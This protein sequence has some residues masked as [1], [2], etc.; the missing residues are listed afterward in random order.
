[1]QPGG[2]W[3]ER[4]SDKSLTTACRLKGVRAPQS[5]SSTLLNPT[6][7]QGH[8]RLPS[9]SGDR[10]IEKLLSQAITTDSP[11]AKSCRGPHERE[12]VHDY[13]RISLHRILVE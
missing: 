8:H 5:L 3:I 6:T 13:G 4:L 7:Q 1:M 9:L 12:R 2:V 10:T 11:Q